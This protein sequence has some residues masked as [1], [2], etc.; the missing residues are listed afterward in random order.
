M[1][2]EKTVNIFNF[3]PLPDDIKKNEKNYAAVGILIIN[4]SQILFIKRSDQMPTHKGHIAFPGGRSEENDKNFLDTAT[5]E[6]SEE[7]LIPPNSFEP[8]G[9]LEPIDTVEY[10]YKVHPVIF[11][12]EYQPTRFDNKEVQ[13]IHLVP[14]RKLNNPLLWEYKG[15]YQDDWIFK[16]EE[17]ELWGASAKMIRNLLNIQLSK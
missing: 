7:L 13:S 17:E 14:I 5:R 8:V 3:F 10:K 11:S 2:S 6:V 1:Q 15:R 12:I 9:Y 4:S 16:I